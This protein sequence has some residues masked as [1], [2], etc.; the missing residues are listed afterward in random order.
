MGNCG[1][2]E[3]DFHLVSCS[4]VSRRSLHSSHGKQSDYY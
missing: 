1:E 3:N 2:A 4:D